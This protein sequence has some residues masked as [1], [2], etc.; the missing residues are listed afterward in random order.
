MRLTH[1]HPGVDL[2]RV[3]AKTGFEIQ[4]APEVM[5]TEPPT[6]EELRLLREVIDPLGIRG[7]ERLSGPARREALKRAL[8]LEA[9]HSQK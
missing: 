7:L 6:E 5:T 3:R 4:L 9:A 8:T 1:L 2:D